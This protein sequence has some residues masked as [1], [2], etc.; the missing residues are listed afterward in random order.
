[1][2]EAAHVYIVDDDKSV[3]DSLSWLVESLGI[4]LVASGADGEFLAAYD[5]TGP[6]CLI[7]D[8][9]MPNM[10]GL[11]LQSALL[12]RGWTLPV[13][14][15]T[16]YG[17]VPMAVSTLQK[18]AID[19]LEKPFEDQAL[20]DRIGVALTRDRE[21]RRAAGD[22]AAV[23][24][25]IARLTKREREVMHCVVGG[26]ANKVIAAELGISIKTVEAH[27]EQVMH[28]MGA[29]SL[30]ELVQMAMRSDEFLAS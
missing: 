28:K 11:E 30:A 23:A 5:G 21:T 16:A 10:S 7:T 25:A 20:L 27:R 17:N 6:A 14:F 1:M 2:T 8:G 24:A 13:I 22:R 19:F 3:R 18:G 15:I 4:P 9:R 26:R 29:G 12:E